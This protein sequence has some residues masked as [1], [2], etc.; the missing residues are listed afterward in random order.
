MSV[1]LPLGVAL[2]GVL[3]G[4]QMT[5]LCVRAMESRVSG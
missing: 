2:C 5:E 4:V 1:G 3:R